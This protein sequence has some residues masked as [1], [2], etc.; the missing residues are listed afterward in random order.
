MKT[1]YS[2]HLVVLP[3][4]R[5]L[6]S[7][8][9]S[10]YAIALYG[11]SRSCC[12]AAWNLLRGRQT[13]A[14]GCSLQARGSRQFRMS[15]RSLRG[16]SAQGASLSRVHG[17]PAGIA[18]RRLSDGERGERVPAQRVNAH[19]RNVSAVVHAPA[20]ISG[21]PPPRA[22]FCPLLYLAGTYHPLALLVG[23]SGRNIRGVLCPE[24]H[25]LFHLNA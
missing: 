3:M 8:N 23:Q 24:Y 5:L 10:P 25:A 6:T 16:M 21:I 22:H 12:C 2:K 19:H 17:L 4:N 14:P 11:C 13:R 1:P 18:P 9:P 15:L 7:S 20:H